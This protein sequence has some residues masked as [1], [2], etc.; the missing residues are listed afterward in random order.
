MKLRVLH[1][2]TYQYAA[3]AVLS[4]HQAHLRPAHDAFQHCLVH[5]LV[6]DPDPSEQR[7]LTDPL[8]NV[9]CEFAVHT[10]HERLDVR[11]DSIVE[12]A[13]GIAFDM[14]DSPAWET[15]AAQQVFSTETPYSFE[16]LFALPSAY[17]EAH[18]S[19]QEVALQS[20]LPQRP[21]LDA[22]LALMEQLHQML[23]FDPGSTTID[24]PAREAL[25]RGHGVCQDF[26]HIMLACLRSLGLPAR[27]ESGYLLTQPPEGQ[28]R[29][30]GADASH[31]WISVPQN[32]QW[33][34]FDP[35]NARCGLH[36]PGEDYV[37]VASGRDFGDVS[38]LRG[39]V[40][41]GGAHQ[42]H[43]GVTVAPPDAF[44]TI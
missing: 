24:T 10:P 9:R 23:R 21:W 42:L 18:P 8:G 15:V 44:P 38:P 12:T 33:H 14:L 16:S 31:A 27:Y 35:T 3:P 6:V 11:A 13:G 20:F 1:H 7:E 29:L 40:H 2:T 32:G 28:P 17:V 34:H 39:V 25:E 30:L 4:L 26:A 22:C 43:V 19:F 36:A 5:A 41:G 37:R